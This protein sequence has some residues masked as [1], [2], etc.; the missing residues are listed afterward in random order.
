MPSSNLHRWCS[1]RNLQSH[2]CLCKYNKCQ[3]VRAPLGVPEQHWFVLIIYAA[4]QG[5]N[6]LLVLQFLVWMSFYRLPLSSYD[7]SS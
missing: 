4:E 3:K 5:K 6:Y 2:T 1:R 7:F